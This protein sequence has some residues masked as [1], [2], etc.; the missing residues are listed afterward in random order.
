[1]FAWELKGGIQLEEETVQRVSF[2]SHR[3]A[4]TAAA[5]HLA[6]VPNSNK[7]VVPLLLW[8]FEGGF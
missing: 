6:T 2:P 8:I 1:V 3:G 5:L 4:L 7:V